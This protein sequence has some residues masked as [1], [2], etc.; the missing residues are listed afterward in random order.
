MGNAF[1]KN[2][3][4]YNTTDLYK[5]ILEWAKSDQFRSDVNNQYGFD[6]NGSIYSEHYK[7][8]ACCSGTNSFKLP[9]PAFVSSADFNP[10]VPAVQAFG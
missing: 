5:S 4:K 2:K 3:D 10:L 7:K 6:N 8:R 1:N 9:F